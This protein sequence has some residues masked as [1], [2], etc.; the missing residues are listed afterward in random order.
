[1][2]WWTTRFTTPSRIL[3]RRRDR[4]L[5]STRGRVRRDGCHIRLRIHKRDRPDCVSYRLLSA[6]PCEHPSGYEL[7]EGVF[8]AKTVII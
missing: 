6:R 3:C 1:M 5:L 4:P 8:M 7:L 2:G